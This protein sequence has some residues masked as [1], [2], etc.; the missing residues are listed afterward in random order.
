MK[1][2]ILF[3]L[4]LFASAAFATE[5]QP[6]G[7]D[8]TAVAGASAVAGAAALNNTNVSVS[9][10]ISNDVRANASAFQAQAQKQSQVQAA[11]ANS[12]GNSLTVNEAPIPAV[13]SNTTTYGGEYTV[14]NVPA[15]FSGNV[16]PTAPCMGSSTVGGAGVGFGFSIGSSWTDDE[17]GIR[18]T[19]RSFNALGLKDDAVRVLCTSKYAATAVACK[20]K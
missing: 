13:T 20:E 4:A 2:V 10:R 6:T 1:K 17:C 16:Y 5:R 15:V 3:C 11:S 9:N 18:E 14:K 19:S 12:G 7:G 8:A